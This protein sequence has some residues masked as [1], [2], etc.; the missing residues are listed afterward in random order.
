[1]NP[2]ARMVALPS[3]VCA[4]LLP[5][6]GYVHAQ[7]PSV[8]CTGYLRPAQS[9]VHIGGSLLLRGHAYNC[10][11]PA[12]FIPSAAIVLYKPNYGYAGFR[13]AVARNGTYTL[14][15]RI[16]TKLFAASG[17][18]TGKRTVVPARPGTY[19]F[20]VRVFDMYLPPPKGADAHVVVLP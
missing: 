12:G 8:Q 14:R 5:T 18:L 19:Y 15:I 2:F 7:R 13:I 3:V 1:M 4:A 6:V 9:R 20:T 17:L 10:K 11:G 16:P